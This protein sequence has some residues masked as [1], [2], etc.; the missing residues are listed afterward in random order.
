[1]GGNVQLYAMTRWRPI[2]RRRRGRR[3]GGHDAALRE[4]WCG[5]RGGDQVGGSGVLEKYD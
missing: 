4:H 5:L 3:G 1:M 2:Q